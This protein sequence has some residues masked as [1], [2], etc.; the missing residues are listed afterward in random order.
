[1][2]SLRWDVG[3]VCMQ[4]CTLAKAASLRQISPSAKAQSERTQTFTIILL[5]L[6]L[7]FVHWMS[8]SDD[9]L[10]DQYRSI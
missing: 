10:S 1:M 9:W 4:T 5:L 8:V 7:P 2:A 6:H 3:V